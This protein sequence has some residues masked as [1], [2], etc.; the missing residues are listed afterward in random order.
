MKAV[1]LDTV[2]LLATWNESD[3]WHERAFPVYQQILRDRR[4]VVTTTAV[5][6]E[7]S[8]A[9]ARL[10]CRDDLLALKLRL[11]RNNLIMPVEDTDWSAA[12]LAYERGSRGSAGIVDQISFTVM[13]RLGITDAFTNDQHFRTAG[14]TPLF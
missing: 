14:F 5:L 13:H 11:E 8:N 9:A 4:L 10:A 3:Q 12:W 6:L 1:F 2:G 7:C